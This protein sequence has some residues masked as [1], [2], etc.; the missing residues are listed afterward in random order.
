MGTGRSGGLRKVT[1]RAVRAQVA[2]AAA[3]L[4]AEQGFENTTVDQIAAAVGMSPRSVFRYFATKEDMV[5]GE[6]IQ[7][8]EQLTAVLRERPADEPVWTALRIALGVCV[9]ELEGEGGLQRATMLATTPALRI[10]MLTKQR[11]WEDLLVPEVTRRLG[12]KVKRPELV[13]HAIVASALACLDVAAT[14]WV[15]GEGAES[16]DALFSTALDAI[17]APR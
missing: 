1:R 3:E 9:A 8:G 11:A 12:K 2:A 4:F 13:G 7:L 17:R 16:L 5:V 14:E 6:L 10:A 15:R